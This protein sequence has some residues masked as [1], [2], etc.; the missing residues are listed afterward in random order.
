MIKD[1]NFQEVLVC[2]YLAVRRRYLIYFRK[3]YVKKSLSSRKGKCNRCPCCHTRGLFSKTGKCKYLVN[4]SCSIYNTSI[5]YLCKIYPIDEKDKT[6][7][8]KKNC[9]YHWK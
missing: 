3:D 9:G 2:L 5:D 7:F 8:S 6:P 4:N 1:Y